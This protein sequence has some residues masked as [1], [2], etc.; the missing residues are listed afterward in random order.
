MAGY[1]EVLGVTEETIPGVERS[2]SELLDA[3]DAQLET[4]PFLLGSRACVGDFALHGSLYAHVYRDPD[5]QWFDLRPHVVAWMHR[6]RE[7]AVG[8][9]TFSCGMR[10]RARCVRSSRWRLRSSGRSRVRSSRG[11]TTSPP[12][13]LDRPPPGAW[14]GAD[15][16]RRRPWPAQDGDRDAVE[17]PAGTRRPRVRGRAAKRAGASAAGGGWRR[18]LRD[19]EIESPVVRR[20]GRATF[21]DQTNR[22]APSAPAASGSG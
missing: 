6:L 5:L 16:H 19:I 3:L 12:S 20:S 8:E 11:S 2:L 7:P 4:T 9:G 15:H 18:G 17:D 22:E 21:R 10:C 14:M 13:T 1:R